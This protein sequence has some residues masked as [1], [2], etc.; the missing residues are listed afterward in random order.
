LTD[1]ATDVSPSRH[2]ERLVDLFRFTFE[3]CNILPPISIHLPQI[4]VGQLNH[5][6][7]QIYPDDQATEQVDIVQVLKRRNEKLQQ[8]MVG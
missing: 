1:W 4:A 8:Q 2:F 7:E 6:S 5:S 3:M